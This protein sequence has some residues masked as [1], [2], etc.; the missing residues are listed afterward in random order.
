MVVQQANQSSFEQEV[1]SS[2]QPVICLFWTGYCSACKQT[3]AAISNM[4]KRLG[5]SARFW[6][7]NVEEHP[8]IGDAAGI[9]VVPTIIVF[10]N[11]RPTA[12]IFGKH[13]ED[14]LFQTIEEAIIS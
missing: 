14:E 7:V 6:S 11:G 10:R 12:R 13:P 4:E 2:R 3:H 8:E 5:D 1:L 9:L